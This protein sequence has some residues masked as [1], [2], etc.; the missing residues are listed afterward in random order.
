MTQLL[1]YHL[2]VCAVLA[3]L[4]TVV[5][6]LGRLRPAL[7]HLLW[8]VVLVK[9]TL[10][11]LI[12][13]PWA[14]PDVRQ[15][16]PRSPATTSE[17][18]APEARGP[19]KW[20]WLVGEAPVETQEVVALEQAGWRI[21]PVQV[22]CG[23]WVLGSVI[24]F[25]VQMAR[26]GRFLRRIRAGE[27][28]PDWLVA[29]VDDLSRRF[30]LRVPEVVVLKGIHSTFVWG[31]GRSRLLA[32]ENAVSILEPAR[33]RGIVAHEL[34]HLK[35]RDQWV[36]VF[37]L[38]AGCVWWWNPVFWYVRRKLRAQAELACDAWAVWA[39]PEQRREYAEALVGV[40]ELAPERPALAPVLGM[41][42]GA[43]VAIERRITM[44]LREQIP[45]GV[46]RVAWVLALALVALVVP[47]WSQ[48]AQP[49]PAAP[50]VAGIPEAASAPAEK[51]NVQKALDSE[52]NVQFQE[53][54]LSE[55]TE[56]ISA[57][58]EVNIVLDYRVIIPPLPKAPVAGEVGGRGTSGLAPGAAAPSEETEGG[59]RLAGAPG[60]SMRGGPG[61]LFSGSK[62]VSPDGRIVTDGM[63]EYVSL[64][65]I[66]VRDA[67][68]AV[69]RP[70]NLTFRAEPN[71]IWISSPAMIES[72]D[73]RPKPPRAMPPESALG[74]ALKS[75]VNINFENVHIRDLT[76]FIHS[77]WAVN[78]ML[79]T[80]VIAP[81]KGNV[82]EKKVGSPGYVT[83]GMVR[84][85]KMD[86]IPLE[87]ALDAI[88]RPLDLTFMTD[89]TF[90]W[91]SSPE[92]IQQGPLPAESA[93]AE[94]K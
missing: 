90:I 64:E 56:F 7:C 67:L 36:G 58:Y 92:L 41:G 53:V 61:N 49:A 57:S 4:V 71:L 85:L 12:S 69:L 44:I 87:E 42:S 68:T 18:A 59:G 83:D 10:P 93:P 26:L 34:A 60:A 89:T 2:A 66:S 21:T 46:P 48:E 50:E 40:M 11:P 88:L 38:A 8:L 54:H 25:G 27:A 70:L 82:G 32:P 75:Q 17:T 79:D 13:W 77:S 84:F 35:R 86:N 43:M 65:N 19:V 62:P 76:D 37:E 28:A 80:R 51:T 72:D 63:V 45:C 74:K 1:A 23:I 55:I 9:L 30:G 6:R 5:C 3:F 33:W 16:I 29:H 15:A 39:L 31:F 47:G 22:A 20:L 14:F 81:A 91:I 73:A 24:V 52:V 78:I 94:T